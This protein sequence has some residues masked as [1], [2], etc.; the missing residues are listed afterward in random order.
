MDAAFGPI[1][2]GQFRSCV[3]PAD[4]PYNLACNTFGGRPLQ[5]AFT[6]SQRWY[7]GVEYRPDLDADEPLFFRDTYA[8]TVVPSRGNEIYSTAIVD[9]NG[10]LVPE[11]F[12]LP[13]GGGHV[14]GTGNPADGRPPAQ[15]GSDPGTTEDLSLGVDVTVVRTQQNRS[16]AVVRIRPGRPPS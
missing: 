9:A 12:G 3:A 16:R 6:D 2:R 8:S 13:L 11:H 4:A 14:T 1:G 10:Q 15:D 5:L 7:P